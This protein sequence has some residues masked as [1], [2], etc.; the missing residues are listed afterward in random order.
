MRWACTVPLTS[1]NPYCFWVNSSLLGRYTSAAYR[2]T[3]G[4]C[5]EYMAHGYLQF[6]GCW[7]GYVVAASTRSVWWTETSRPH[8]S[9]EYYI[10]AY[11]FLRIFV[12]RLYCFNARLYVRVSLLL[13]TF[14]NLA[15]RAHCVSFE[16]PL[17]GG[18][19]PVLSS[20]KLTLRFL[21]SAA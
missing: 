5:G 17:P 21:S 3:E 1:V 6:G 10:T 2:D 4:N 7:P 19:L 20:L 12:I 11:S 16:C 8:S 18:Q 14:L 13:L 9:H 15:A